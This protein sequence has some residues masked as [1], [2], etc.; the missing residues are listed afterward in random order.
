MNKKDYNRI[1]T[2]Y[3]AGKIPEKLIVEMI[4]YQVDSSHE[5][6]SNAATI[7]ARFYRK[8]VKNG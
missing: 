4:L 6:A 8:E 1:I 3:R 2:L 7:I 5:Y